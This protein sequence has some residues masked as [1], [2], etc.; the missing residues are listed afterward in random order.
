MELLPNITVRKQRVRESLPT[1]IV[2]Q[3]MAEAVENLNRAG[4]LAARVELANEALCKL[5]ALLYVLDTDGAWCN[6]DATT[7]RLLV[8]APWGRSGWQRWG[9]RQHEGDTLRRVLLARANEKRRRPLLYQYDKDARSWSMNVEDYPTL[10]DAG[11]WLKHEPV[12][13]NEW[14]KG[15]LEGRSAHSGRM[16]NL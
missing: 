6:I 2:K 7:H 5:T 15:I 13:L 10:K 3:R 8:P 4:E 14:R 1:A 12:S 9:L 11:F 16:A